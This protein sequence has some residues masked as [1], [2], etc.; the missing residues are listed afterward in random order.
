MQEGLQPRRTPAEGEASGPEATAN[1]A[2][3][4]QNYFDDPSAYG[5]FGLDTSQ[6]PL[7]FN[8]DTSEDPASGYK[9]LNPQNLYVSYM[10]RGDYDQ[11]QFSVADSLVNLGTSGASL[12]SM[13]KNDVGGTKKLNTTDYQHF[14][15]HANNSCAVPN[16]NEGENLVAISNIYV[17]TSTGS[18]DADRRSRQEIQLWR[19]EKDG[20]SPQKIG[21]ANLDLVSGQKDDLQR[22]DAI[23]QD[24]SL[25]LTALAGGDFDG[26]GYGELAV[27][28]PDAHT[29][30]IDF[31]AYAKG[32]GFFKSDWSVPLSSLGSQFG[33]TFKNWY[34]PIVNL[35]VIPR[36]TEGTTTTTLH[37]RE[38][39]LHQLQRPGQAR[40]IHRHVHLFEV[41]RTRHQHVPGS[42]PLLPQLRLRA[43]ALRLHR[44]HRPQ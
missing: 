16:R 30:R 6:T 5:D 14:Q 19:F 20:A 38:H 12:D 17:G 25:G 44:R 24:G 26:D 27:Y 41:H 4:A 33:G 23:D 22:L 21:Q 7:D 9:G 43:D 29:P 15:Y 39:A 10:N 32:V 18:S 11:G 42:V 37:H 34:L 36:T 2:S 40:P 13:L 31:Y 1:D 28:V 35:S 8:G 3:Q